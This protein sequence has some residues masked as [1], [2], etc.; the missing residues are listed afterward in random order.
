MASTESTVLC[1]ADGLEIN[2]NIVISPE[3]YESIGR[4]AF[5]QKLNVL[6]TFSGQLPKDM[7]MKDETRERL[8]K[9]E[10]NYREK[11][12]TL[13]KGGIKGNK[14]LIKALIKTERT[15]E[16]RTI[17]DGD[18]NISDDAKANFEND[19]NTR[20]EN[21][22]SRNKSFNNAMEELGDFPDAKYAKRDLFERL[23][24]LS[25]KQLEGKIQCLP[26]LQL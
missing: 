21:E 8:Q 7:N 5:K 11:I 24:E 22:K 26:A 17:I 19:W 18:L 20:L 15:L 9:V 12:E 13:N 14:E 10:N 2:K 25:T 3:C 4:D 16:T 6:K 1:T 23:R